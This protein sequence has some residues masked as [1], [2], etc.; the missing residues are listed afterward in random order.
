[1]NNEKNILQRGSC[2][3]ILRQWNRKRFGD[4]RRTLIQN[5]EGQSP[6][7]LKPGFETQFSEFFSKGPPTYYVNINK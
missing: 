7:Q 1:M 3:Q 5:V 4:A 6:K 2:I